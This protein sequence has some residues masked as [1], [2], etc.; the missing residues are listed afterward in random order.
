MFESIDMPFSNLTMYAHMVDAGLHSILAKNETDVP[1]KIKRGA[2]LGDICEL[3][4]DGCYY[5]DHGLEG[6][7]TLAAWTFK[8]E[9]HGSW[10]RRALTATVGA[11]AV[12]SCS[13]STPQTLFSNNAAL[14]TFTIPITQPF[15]T[16]F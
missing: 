10:L 12:T 1:I 16:F 2:R 13:V 3:E 9:H 5:A 4:F 14:H 7:A 11:M 15:T 6:T 8:R